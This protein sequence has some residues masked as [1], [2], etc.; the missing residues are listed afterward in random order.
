MLYFREV[1]IAEVAGTGGVGGRRVGGE[2]E[3]A[4]ALML[5]VGLKKHGNM[6]TQLRWKRRGNVRRSFLRTSIL[7]IGKMPRLIKGSAD[8]SRTDGA[9]K[10][11]SFMSAVCYD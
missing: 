8:K 11:E 6:H 10:N 9:K 4:E 7:T 5:S 3:P 1:A 2:A